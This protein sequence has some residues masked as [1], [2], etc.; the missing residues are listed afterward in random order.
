MWLNQLKIALV[1]KDTDKLSK[2]MDDIPQLESKK[3]II[4][5]LYLIKEASVLVQTL[6]AETATSMKQIKKNL[7]FL[8]STQEPSSNRLDIK[9]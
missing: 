5:A 4:E 1:E 9:S 8:K 6:K 2:L 7:N 3:E